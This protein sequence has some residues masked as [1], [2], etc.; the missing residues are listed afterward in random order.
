MIILSESPVMRWFLKR[1]H[2]END[3]DKD[4]FGKILLVPEILPTDIKNRIAKVLLSSPIIP[5]E[6]K[7]I[8][9]T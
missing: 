5:Y 8:I 3:K 2:H 1:Q 4:V 7:Y 6:S 9:S